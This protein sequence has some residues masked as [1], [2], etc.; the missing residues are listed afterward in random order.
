MF[1][2]FANCE[3]FE[4]DYNYDQQLTLPKI[5]HEQEMT[6]EWD[7]DEQEHRK[8]R[9]KWA[10]ENQENDTVVMMQETIIWADGMKIDRELYA[11]SFEKDI[12]TQLNLD[13]KLQALAD[14]YDELWL[15]HYAREFVLD[16]PSEFY[17][18]EKLNQSYGFERILWLGEMMMK[19]LGLINRFKSKQDLIDE[20]W[21]NFLHTYERP[22]FTGPEAKQVF[23]N[24][25]VDNEYRNA[26]DS[27]NL[28]YFATKPIYMKNLKDVWAECITI[29]KSY[30]TVEN[31]RLLQL[32]YR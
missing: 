17:T 31:P 12:K 6:I 4:K 25:C 22:C 32:S 10:F 13:E 15:E 5:P 9:I 29:I 2:F 18:V 1:D 24:Y 23:R 21:D 26:I 7:N 19:A 27:Q 11:Q 16:K 14:A 28:W 8:K 3:Y 20:S 30:I